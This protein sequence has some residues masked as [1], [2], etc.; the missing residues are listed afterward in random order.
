MVMRNQKRFAMAFF[1]I[2]LGVFFLVDRLNYFD[3][4]L[5]LLIIG[6][7]LLV[8]YILSGKNYRERV[9]IYLVSGSLLSVWGGAYLAYERIQLLNGYFFYI[10]MTAAAIGLFIIHFVSAGRTDR[11]GKYVQSWAMR[12]AILLIVIEGL[13]YASETLTAYEMLFYM[14]NYWP[15]IL[16]IIGVMILIKEGLH[17]MKKEKEKHV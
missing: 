13:V 6:I 1:M 5:S 4:S 11:P 17:M 3:D 14:S 2:Y 16:I 7:G 10:Y 15:V 12:L 8:T 9:G